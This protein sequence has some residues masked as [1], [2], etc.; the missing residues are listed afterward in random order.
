MDDFSPD[1]LVTIDPNQN[2]IPELNALLQTRSDVSDLLTLVSRSH[3]LEEMLQ[4]SLENKDGALEELRNALPAPDSAASPSDGDAKADA[5]AND[6]D[7]SD[8][9]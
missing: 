8:P 6:S 1:N 2:G 3:Q 4:Q 9:Q 7:S 5:S